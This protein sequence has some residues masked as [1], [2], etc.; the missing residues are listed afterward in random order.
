MDLWVER[1]ID[2]SVSEIFAATMIDSL[3]LEACNKL[4]AENDG[5]PPSE[6]YGSVRDIDLRLTPVPI[7][8]SQEG[9]IHVFPLTRIGGKAKEKL[10]RVQ[11]DGELTMTHP[12]PLSSAPK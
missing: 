2:I 9:F 11:R 7:H 6:K 8:M 1:T 4:S 5:L 10:L 12:S 3:V